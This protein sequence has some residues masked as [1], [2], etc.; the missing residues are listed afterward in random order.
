MKVLVADDDRVWVEV[1][2]TAFRKKGFEV[3]P[4]FDGMQTM[5]AAMQGMPDLIVL[6]VQMPGGTGLDTLRRL[7]MSTKTSPIPVIVVSGA[8]DPNMPRTVTQLGAAQ[9]VRKPTTVDDVMA[10]VRDVLRLS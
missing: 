6:D 4:A 8:A 9:F 10:A 7:K 3:L 5:M 1:L 2:G